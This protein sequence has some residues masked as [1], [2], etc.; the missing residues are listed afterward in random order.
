MQD[1]AGLVINL[2]GFKTYPEPP[3]VSRNM[4]LLTWMGLNLFVLSVQVEGGC[5][6]PRL[7][8]GDWIVI[9]SRS[10]EGVRLRGVHLR[11]EGLVKFD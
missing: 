1:V 2:S 8:D 9:G 7:P 5:L 4:A 10:G 6:D 11:H 3:L